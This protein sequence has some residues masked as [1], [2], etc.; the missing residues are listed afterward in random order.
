M[1]AEKLLKALANQRRLIILEMLCKSSMTVTAVSDS[2]HLSMR[3]TSKHL[4]VLLKA[5]VVGHKQI[6]LNVFYYL[7]EPRHSVITSILTLV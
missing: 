7:I 6:G 4:Q 3:S 1:Q 2:I 5:E